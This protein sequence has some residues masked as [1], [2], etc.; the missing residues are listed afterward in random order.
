MYKTGVFTPGKSFIMA[1]VRGLTESWYQ[2]VDKAFLQKPAKF[3]ALLRQA[4]KH[5]K[6]PYTRRDTG[7][8]IEAPDVFSRSS[9]ALEE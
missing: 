1:N 2:R 8:M 9:P 6:A 7:G 3:A 4:E 5:V